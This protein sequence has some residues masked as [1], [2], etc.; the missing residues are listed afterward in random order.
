MLLTREA[1]TAAIAAGRDLTGGELRSD[2][3]RS[4]TREAT[5]EERAK[6]KAELGDEAA[7]GRVVPFCISTEARASDGHVISAEGWRLER[8]RT[9]PIVL[10]RHDTW[11][12]RL[13]DSVVEVDT[14]AR[15]LRALCSFLP[16]EVSELSWSLGEVAASRGHAASV[17]FRILSHRPA[18]EEVTEEIPWALDID[19]AE[20]REW[21]LVNI[22]ADAG[23]LADARAKGVDLAPIAAAVSRLLD[24]VT[25]ARAEL[26]RLYA[27]VAPEAPTVL[28]VPDT[29]PEAPQERETDPS[30]LLPAWDVS[31]EL[32]ESLRAR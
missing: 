13:G 29:A 14:E 5:E 3:A 18:P 2:R 19:A 1:L 10:W 24:E 28:E 17:G 15:E 11:E 4:L 27:V 21:S 20:L 22:G 8:Y 31:A 9:N 26:E 7:A 23:A 25:E 16:R 12:P 6:V 32:R 30:T